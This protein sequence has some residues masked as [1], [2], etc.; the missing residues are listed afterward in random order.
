M[1]TFFLETGKQLSAMHIIWLR[2]PKSLFVPLNPKRLKKKNFFK[3]I[4]L[5]KLKNKTSL[6][7]KL[8]KTRTV[9]KEM[10]IQNGTLTKL[11]RR[12]RPN[13][14]NYNL[15]FIKILNLCIYR[16]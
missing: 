8:I 6:L 2:F 3:I 1:S 4:V 7:R 9:I 14:T 13:K 16:I 5:K 10:K 11:F 15:S 12:T